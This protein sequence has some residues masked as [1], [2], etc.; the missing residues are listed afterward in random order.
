MP[1]PQ[2]TRAAGIVALAVLVLA[3]AFASE[4]RA[5]TRAQWV[6]AANA[7]CTK[8]F[9]PGHE[10]LAAWS[11][12]PPTTVREWVAGLTRIIN[13]ETRMRHDLGVIPRP[14]ADR[15]AIKTMLMWLDQGLAQMRLARS[16]E[17]DLNLPLYKKH[18]A[19]ALSAGKQFSFVADE[20]GAH[21][22]AHG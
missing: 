10:L 12:H 13:A 21:V 1:L 18:Y 15:A 22:C 19:A 8:G 2:S 7:A 20:L 5:E 3:A 16:A 9:A 6:V 4:A 11:K 17:L 14:A